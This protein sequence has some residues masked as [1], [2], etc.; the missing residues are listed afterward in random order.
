MNF[1]ELIP[2]VE[3]LIFSNRLLEKYN[4][5]DP[6]DFLERIVSERIERLFSA[7]PTFGYNAGFINS[8]L[9][10]LPKNTP[11]KKAIRAH[12]E[13]GLMLEKL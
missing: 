2:D 1:E 6:Q 11:R 10:L 5:F 4:I 8:L 9:S 13:L 3:S 12:L 7:K